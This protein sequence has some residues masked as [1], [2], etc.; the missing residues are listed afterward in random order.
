[1]TRL[2]RKALNLSRSTHDAYLGVK[3]IKA[4]ALLLLLLLSAPRAEAVDGYWLDQYNALLYLGTW[5]LDKE[6]K[7]MQN[8]GARSLMLHSDSLP[9]LILEW[10]AWRSKI[11]A[12]MNSIAW[13]QK[14]NKKNL[15][16]AG[17]L[18]GF[19]A[20]QIDDHFFNNP[21]IGL[22]KLRQITKPKKLWCSFQPRQYS[23]RFASL[24][25]HIDVQIYR[26]GCIRTGDI[27]YNLGLTGKQ[28]TAISV[29]HDGSVSGDDQLRCIEQDLAEMGSRMFIF[30]WKN[31][32]G[33]P[34]IKLISQAMTKIYNSAQSLIK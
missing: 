15:L 25:D 1:M 31:Q 9:P 28:N 21:P 7:E 33:W 12:N 23:L 26:L 11:V 20:I 30:K 17:K 27:A 2:R 19:S 22:N 29:Y 34:G 14:P 10:I 24:C 32:E 5:R 3:R 6:L 18:K 16:R 4:P 8:K 13:I